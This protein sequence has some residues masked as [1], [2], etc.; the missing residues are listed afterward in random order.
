VK[1]EPQSDGGLSPWCK[2]I[3]GRSEIQAW[4]LTRAYPADS[5]W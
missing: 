1:P 4:P 2:L 3:R 5:L